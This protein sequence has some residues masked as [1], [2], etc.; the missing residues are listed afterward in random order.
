MVSTL[1]PGGGTRKEGQGQRF[2]SV[3]ALKKLQKDSKAFETHN[4]NLIGK[5]LA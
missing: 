2:R 1:H 5:Q 3:G 4:K